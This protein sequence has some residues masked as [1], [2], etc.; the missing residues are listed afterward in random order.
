[1]RELVRKLK[2]T[3]KGIKSIYTLWRLLKDAKLEV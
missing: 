2:Q 3:A 1:M